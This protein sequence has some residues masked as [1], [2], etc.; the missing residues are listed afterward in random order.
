MET[1]IS[2]SNFFL[3]FAVLSII[4]CVGFMYRIQEGIVINPRCIEANA[5]I[6]KEVQ[7]NRANWILVFDKVG[8]NQSQ[9]HKSITSTKEKIED[10]FHEHDID[11]EDMEFSFFTKEENR[12]IKK[13]QD[14]SPIYRMGYKLTIK[15][16]KIDI[17]LNLKNNLSD[18]YKQDI[19]FSVNHLDFKYSLCDEIKHEIAMEVAKKA[20]NKAQDLADALDVR[21]KNIYRVYE[22]IFQVQYNDL[23]GLYIQKLNAKNNHNI[24]EEENTLQF[25]KRKIKASIRIDVE[26]K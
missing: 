7:A 4:I 2:T 22:P 5:E 12:N 11:E 13:T 8:T 1:K 20:L 15:S 16:K 21:I 9:L 6:E 19:A 14:T 24:N 25:P 23:N 18:L 26:I 17:I 10:F 3:L